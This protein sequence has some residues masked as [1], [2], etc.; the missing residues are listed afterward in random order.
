MYL[1]D[2]QIDEMAHAAFTTYEV[3]ADANAA[4]RAAKEHAVDEFGIT[5]RKSAVLHAWNLA[6]MQWDEEVIKAK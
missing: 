2:A 1:T 3:T 5:P 4:I 6:K